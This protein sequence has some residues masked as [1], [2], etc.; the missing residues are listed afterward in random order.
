MQELFLQRAES[1]GLVF[2]VLL[3]LGMMVEGELLLFA[4]AFAAWNGLLDPVL[5]A[6][7]SGTGIFLGSV[8]WYGLG[9]WLTERTRLAPVRWII[10]ATRSFTDQLATHPA[11][12]LFLSSFVYGLYRP[13]QIRAGMLGMGLRRYLGIAVPTTL[14]WIAVVVSLAWIARETV[15]P[16]LRYLHYFELALL[17][18]FVLFAVF[19]GA[20]AATVRGL[21]PGLA[22]KRKD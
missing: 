18:A 6:L 22:R 2:Y 12:T 19:Q 1:W 16:I 9:A 7:S 17:A 11:R 5:L 4:T 10:G 21:F 20:L 8:G 15:A 3:A 13:T 14:A